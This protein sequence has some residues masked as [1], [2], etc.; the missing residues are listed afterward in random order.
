MLETIGLVPTRSSVWELVAVLVADSLGAGS[1][2]TWSELS[3]EP[4]ESGNSAKRCARP[5]P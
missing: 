4:L 2:L 5:P 1:R 3:S